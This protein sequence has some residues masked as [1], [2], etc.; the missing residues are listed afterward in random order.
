MK[1]AFFSFLLTL[2]SA[3]VYQTVAQADATPADSINNI[4]LEEVIVS[5]TRAGTETPVSYT[6][7]NSADI[8]KQNAGRNIP[9]IL[10]YTPSLVSF[11]EDGLGVGNTYFRIPYWD[12]NAGQPGYTPSWNYDPGKYPEVPRDVSAAAITASAL[13]ELSGL[14][15]V[16]TGEKYVKAAEEML[17]SMISSSYLAEEGTNGGFILQHASG[18]VPG[19]HEV[20]VPLSYA[21]YYFIEALMRY[22]LKVKTD[23]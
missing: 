17:S 4:R 22:K 18:G 14:L 6:N 5:G 16:E 21:D 1:K 2:F 8:K 12:F 19:N 9:A 20:D 3:T 7:I 15:D 13:L 11:T 10:Q 23:E